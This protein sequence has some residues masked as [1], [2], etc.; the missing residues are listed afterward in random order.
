MFRQMML[1]FVLHNIYK[2]KIQLGLWSLSNHNEMT[3]TTSIT[4]PTKNN[5]FIDHNKNKNTELFDG[6]DCRNVTHLLNKEPDINTIRMNYIKLALLDKLEDEAIPEHEKIRLVREYDEIY[7]EKS[8]YTMD[9]WKDIV[10][11]VF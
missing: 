5:Y 7:G 9:I 6:E 4:L 3:Q 1:G 8:K 10:M 11:T 2:Y